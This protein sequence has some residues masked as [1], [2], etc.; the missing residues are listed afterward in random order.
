[1]T[2]TSIN[3]DLR[4]KAK[5]SIDRAD[6]TTVKMIL[7]MLEVKEKEAVSETTHDKEIVKRFDDYEQ[8]KVVP[9]SLDE[10][11]KRVRNNHKKLLKARK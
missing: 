6:D 11:E 1:M 5:Q 7:A 10:L 3:S 2:H 4:K 9:L 8:G